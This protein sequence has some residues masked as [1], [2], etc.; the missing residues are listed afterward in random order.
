MKYCTNCI[1]PETRPDQ[2]LNDNGL[3]NACISYKKN[4]E[5][6]WGEREKELTKTINELNLDKKKWNCVVP[7]SGGKDSTYQ[8]I[9]AKELG[10]NPVFVTASTCDLS[11]IGRENLE[12]IKNLGFDVIEI[13]NNSKVRAKINKITLDLIGDISWPE[14]VSIFTVPVKFALAYNIPL[15]LWGENPQIEYGGP[16]KSL[17]NNILDQAWMEEFGGLIGFRVS[18]LIDTYNFKNHELEIYKYPSVELL[19]EKSIKGIFLGY[20][21]KWD[22]IRNYEI[23]KKNGFKEFTPELEGC[24]FNFEKIDNFQH[25][26]HDYFKFL[27]FGFARATDQLSYSIRRGLISRSDAIKLA[28]KIEG[29]YPKSYMGK[30]LEKILQ[31][32]NVNENEF[33][34]ISD[35]FTNK[36]IFK[37][38]NLN[39]LI[40]DKDNNLIKIN[41]D[42]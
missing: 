4:Q 15:I 7:G 18:D 13:S 14:H 29:K 42:N 12:N 5:I 34:K 1:M 25:G 36:K 30:S 24:Y 11:E 10:L 9:K 2:Y 19:K 35:N 31:K 26:I 40:K 8:I 16:E 23:A 33:M 27:K 39:E 22:S 17:N 41:Y 3:C 20:Y 21:E 37:T 38:N 6:N 32:I 28:P